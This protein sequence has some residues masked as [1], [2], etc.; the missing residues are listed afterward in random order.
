MVHVVNDQTFM[1]EVMQAGLP[2][3]VDFYADWCGPCR[4]VGPVV[5]RLSA[6]YEGKIKFCKVNVDECPAVSQAFKIMSIPMLAFIKDGKMVDQI[7]GA[8]P[9]NTIAAKLDTLL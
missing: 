6:E 2:V 5:E 4:M 9:R 8:V 1:E 7:V 3:L